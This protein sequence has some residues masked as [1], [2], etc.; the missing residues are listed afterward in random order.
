MDPETSEPEEERATPPLPASGPPLQHI[1]TEPLESD[2]VT[3]APSHTHPLDNLSNVILEAKLSP[4]PPQ[5]EPL[6]ADEDTARVETGERETQHDPPLP[7]SEPP[8]D[9]EVR[10]EDEEE[11]EHE[12]IP[13]SPTSHPP[14]PGTAE[15][16]QLPSGEG[17][18]PHSSNP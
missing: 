1:P 3:R 12:P 13:P 2:T 14:T 9:W 6:A 17:E 15:G 5:S 10:G 11:G 7:T 18:E 8:L 4:P 16:D